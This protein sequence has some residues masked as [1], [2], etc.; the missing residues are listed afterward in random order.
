[1]S[2]SCVVRAPTAISFRGYHFLGACKF[3][4]LFAFIFR[5]VRSSPH[6]RPLRARTHRITRQAVLPASHASPDSDSAQA[7]TLQHN[8]RAMAP[9]RVRGAASLH[10]VHAP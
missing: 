2:D 10:A 9:T 5:F 4:F 7:A 6:L 3:S 1:M 8:H